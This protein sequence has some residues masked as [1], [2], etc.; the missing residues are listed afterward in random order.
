MHSNSILCKHLYTLICYL[1]YLTSRYQLAMFPLREFE[2]VLATS[3][4]E[5]AI[6]LVILR[7][8]SLCQV[9]HRVP[10]HSVLS[11]EEL[12]DEC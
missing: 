1:S 5:K 8:R 4:A 7:T 9:E 12:C 10:V 6:A 3:G 2:D 11:R